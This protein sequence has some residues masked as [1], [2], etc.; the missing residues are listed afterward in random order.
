MR[1][2]GSTAAIS[3]F[4]LL[5][6]S[7]GGGGGGNNGGGTAANPTPTPGPPTAVYT[8]PA[9]ESLSVADVQ[10]II[11][12]AV[13]EAQARGLP[14]IIAVTDRVGNVLGVFQPSDG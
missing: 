5:L 11:A 7:C 4:A 9:Q 12:Q 14:S 6:S 10:R 8:A 2:K 3:A 1:V 13:G